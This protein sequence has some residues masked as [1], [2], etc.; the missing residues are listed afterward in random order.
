MRISI[1]SGGSGWHV[2]DLQRA[3]ERRGHAADLLD[4]RNL[5]ARVRAGRGRSTG[6][7]R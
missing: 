7:T 6:P 4:F 1:L 2:R 3:A 5:S